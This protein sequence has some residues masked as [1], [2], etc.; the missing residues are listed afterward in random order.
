M[1]RFTV[2]TGAIA[3]LRR[4]DVDTDQIIPARFCT[5]TART[6]YA[7]ALFADWRGEPDFVLDRPD[8]RDA[9]VLVA[10]DNFGTGSSRE[11]AVWALRDFGY[12]AVV[13]PRFGDIFRANSLMNGLLTVTVPEWAVE[14]MWQAARA[15][16][17]AEATV[18]L[19][20][21]EVRA[22]GLVHPFDLDA[23]VRDRLLKGLDPIASTLRHEE[24]I[25]AY[26]RSRRATPLTTDAATR[27]RTP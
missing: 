17:G 22:A 20:R 10:G 15:R 27:R 24:D 11:A 5:S 12:R 2:H 8:Y 23:D 19:R 18:D 13:A 14:T 26:E 1:G 4:T 16:P 9:T 3:P 25:A 6:G 7:D 21:L